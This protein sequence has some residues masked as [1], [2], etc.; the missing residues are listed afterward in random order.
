MR[1]G[2]TLDRINSKPLESCDREGEMEREEIREGKEKSCPAA[3]SRHQVDGHTASC[4]LR[5][6]FLH[7]LPLQF[8][9]RDQQGSQFGICDN[10]KDHFKGGS[11]VP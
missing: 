3:A 10:N 1:S 2:A 5:T 11:Q 6:F 8:A 4:G 9:Q 7:K